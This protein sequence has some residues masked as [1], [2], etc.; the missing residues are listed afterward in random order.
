MREMR[1]KYG[2]A[3]LSLVRVC[4]DE[5]ER[6]RERRDEEKEMKRKGKEKRDKWR[7]KEING[8][9]EVCYIGVFIF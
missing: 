5:R 2:A 7:W 4:E 6:E 3:E 8:E 1:E 9:R